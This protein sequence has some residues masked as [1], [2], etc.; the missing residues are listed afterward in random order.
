MNESYITELGPYKTRFVA[1]EATVI[2]YYMSVS[3]PVASFFSFADNWLS[4]ADPVIVN[5]ETS[6]NT[7]PVLKLLIICVLGFYNKIEILTSAGF[8][9]NAVKLEHLP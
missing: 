1:D 9:F 5:M 8:R 7:S 2:D 4:C 3:A 6:S